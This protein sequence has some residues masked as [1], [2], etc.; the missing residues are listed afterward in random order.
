M[1]PN[2]TKAEGNDDQAFWGIT[3]LMAAESGFPDPPPEDPQWLALAQAVFNLQAARWDD[4]SC[5]GGLRWQIFAFNRG[6]NYKN[7]ISQGGFFN[8]A[9][10]L[11]AFTNNQTYY[12]WADKMYAWCE[13]VGLISPSFQVFDGTDSLIKCTE[14]NHD[15][16]YASLAEEDDASM[17][18]DIPSQV[19]QHRNLPPRVRSDVESSIILDASRQPWRELISARPQARPKKSGAIAQKVRPSRPLFCENITNNLNSK[20][21]ASSS[22]PSPSSPA[23]TKQ[24][25][26]KPPAS[27]TSPARN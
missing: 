12:E 14:L 26:S 20:R 22:P 8:L 10:R 19:I 7:S 23:R 21:K 9:V 18:I 25:C 15:L 17:M 2:Q 13:S 6:Y 11:G 5:D 4:D 16:W 3:A 1:P 27:A 24:S